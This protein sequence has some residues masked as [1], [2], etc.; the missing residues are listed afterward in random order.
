MKISQRLQVFCVGYFAVIIP[1]FATLL[2]AFKIKFGLPLML[3]V[4]LSLSAFA[5]LQFG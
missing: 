4:L 1:I 3:A 5:W 2:D